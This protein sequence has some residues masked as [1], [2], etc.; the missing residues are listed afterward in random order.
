MIDK[1]IIIRISKY[2]KYKSLL[3]FTKYAEMYIKY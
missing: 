3:I 2:Y 1:N